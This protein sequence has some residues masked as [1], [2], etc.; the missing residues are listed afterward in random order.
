MNGTEA[1]EWL[2]GFQRFGMNLGLKRIR[3][4]MDYLDHPERHY[5]VVHVAGTNGKGSVCRY[6]ASILKTAGYQ[7]GLYT[8]PHLQTVFE[9]FCI[10]DNIISKKDFANIATMVK[11]AVDHLIDR[12]EQP[13]YFEVCTA[14]MFQFFALR[15]VDIAVIE[16]G[17]GGRYDAT[18]IVDPLVSV[19]TNV[20]K[21][22]QQVLGTQIEDIAREKAGI[23]KKNRPVVTAATGLA[24]DVIKEQAA[25]LSAPVHVITEENI[26]LVQRNEHGQHIRCT[27]GLES[28]TVIT[29]LLGSFQQQNITLAI[30]A[31]E[32]LQIQGLY[33][34]EEAII[35]GIETM[36]HPG[37]MQIL[38]KDP[39][40]LIDGAHNESAMNV[41]CKSI[42][43]LFPKKKIIM[44]L[45]LL[46]DKDISSITK[47]VA[48]YA[49][50]VIITKPN[51]NRAE[52]PEIIAEQLRNHHYKKP[53]KIST[54]IQQAIQ[55]GLQE[56]EKTD[57]ILI[58]GSLY[59]LAA[60]MESFN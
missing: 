22:H 15:Q 50:T 8:S 47:I 57:L 33:L 51:C 16:V 18:N 13:T 9:R 35:Q 31:I 10:N 14:M 45:G 36:H 28:Y 43:E 21:D 26:C 52:N 55:L 58:T 40:V 19:I 41:L 39:L 23:I 27:G 2:T 34:S 1:Q 44:I 56:A 11:P 5:P 38:Q 3:V 42:K 60:A 37:R 46:H 30:T 25:T 59:L 7:V 49:D 48:D 6:I 12:G 32:V 17:L 54:S 53:I 20:S 24:L 29:S 4:L